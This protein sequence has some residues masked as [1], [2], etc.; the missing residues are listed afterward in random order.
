MQEKNLSTGE[1]RSRGGGLIICGDYAALVL[2]RPT[3]MAATK[4]NAL[5][6]N[7]ERAAG[8]PATLA[9][10]FDFE[11]SVASG[12]LARGYTVELSTCPER[13]GQAL[14]SLEGFAMAANG[15]ELTQ[16]FTQ[17]DGSAIERRF[18]IDTLEASC[19]Y[20]Q[21]TPTTTQANQW[22]ERERETL[23]RYTQPHY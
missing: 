7:A 10:L 15:R 19:A 22:F 5:R 13:Q 23:C 21:S 12:S 18:L 14:L 3:P 2:A 11:T 4:S 17:Q 6:E 9:Q 8:D 16:Y 20:P 1:Q